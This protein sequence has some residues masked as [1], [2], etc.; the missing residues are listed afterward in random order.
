MSF[1][2]GAILPHGPI[3]PELTKNPEVMAETRAAME[4]AGRRFSAAKIDTLILLD[5]FSVHAC[6]A[7]ALDKSCSFFI[8]ESTLL[9]GT[10]THAAGTIGRTLERF[11]CDVELAE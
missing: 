8:G 5:P 6:Q 9:I 11:E 2:F 4:E 3:V 7:I 1:V 10:T